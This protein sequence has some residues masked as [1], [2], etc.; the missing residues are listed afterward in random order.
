MELMEKAQF[1]NK[2]GDRVN[3]SL[4]KDGA[5]GYHVI[6]KAQRYREETEQR[7]INKKSVELN[8]KRFTEETT[9]TATA[10]EAQAHIEFNM[11]RAIEGDPTFTM[12]DFIEWQKSNREKGGN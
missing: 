9:I 4:F 12:A 2:L 6:T 1:T 5:G 10:F 3:V 8:V 7:F 11:S